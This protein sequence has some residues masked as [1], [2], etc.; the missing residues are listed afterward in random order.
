MAIQLTQKIVQQFKQHAE[1]DYPHE[2]CG[3]IL[4]HWTKDVAEALEYV[5]AENTKNENRER[6]FLI[7]PKAYQQVE[8]YADEKGL[9]VISIVHSHPEHPDE[10][11][12][13]DRVHAWPGFS[14][15]IISVVTGIAT[16]F[17]SWLL[18]ADRSRFS[19]EKIIIEG[20]N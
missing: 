3:F 9:A 6:R 7:D 13:F 18:D 17:R 12:E 2:C 20:I 15:I 5:H 19:E 8:D 4:G 1:K 16:Q 11:S 10:P 14:Y